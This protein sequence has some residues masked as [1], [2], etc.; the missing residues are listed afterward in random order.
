PP[1]A[2]IPS[3][4]E[5]SAAPKSTFPIAL[6]AAFVV[7]CAAG[8]TLFLVR[9][10]ISKPTGPGGSAVQNHGAIGLASWNTR[11]EYTNVM[12]KKGK[13]TLYQSDFNSGAPDWHFRNGAWTTAGGVFR[14]TAIATDCRA[15]TGDSSWRDYTLSLRAR[16]LG[17][18]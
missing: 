17:G 7:L 1:Q 16:K 4:L 10:K 6:V 5:P 12:V 11:V 3:P 15:I 2:G 9:G 14:Q 18:R 13:K 8:G